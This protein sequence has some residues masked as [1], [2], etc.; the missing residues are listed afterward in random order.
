MLTAV[1]VIGFLICLAVFLV[2]MPAFTREFKKTWREQ[3]AKR[4]K[5]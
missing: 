4:K 1:I 5:T 2:R 3:E